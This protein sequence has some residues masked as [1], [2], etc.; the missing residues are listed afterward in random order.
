MTAP[1]GVLRPGAVSRGSLHRVAPALHARGVGAVVSFLALRVLVRPAARRAAQTAD[2]RAHRR[3]PARAAPGGG[4]D[5]RTRRGAADRADH[6][7]DRRAFAGLGRGIEP[8]L[9]FRPRLTL[10]SVARLRPRALASG[11][12]APGSWAE[13]RVPAT[14]SAGS[15]KPSEA[16][17]TPCWRHAGWYCPEASVI[18][19]SPGPPAWTTASP[20]ATASAS[21]FSIML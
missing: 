16:T 4:A 10:A 2:G 9:L 6:R 13:P 5:R 21:S 18:R 15:G 1:S 11:A 19:I 17:R 8:G 7:A 3:A 14:L 12:R 20:A